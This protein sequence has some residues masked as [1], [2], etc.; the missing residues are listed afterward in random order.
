MKVSWLLTNVEV[1]SLMQ[2][3]LLCFSDTQVLRMQLLLRRHKGGRHKVR[4]NWLLTYV[5]VTSLMQAALLCLSDTQVLRM[6]LL[7]GRHK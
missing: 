2:A 6:Q 4:M 1:T 7:L 5:E 3:A